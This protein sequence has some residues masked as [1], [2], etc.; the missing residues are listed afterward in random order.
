MSG[1]HH[2]LGASE[3]RTCVDGVA[4]P[5]DRQ[6]LGLTQRGLHGVGDLRLLA[7]NGFDVD[8]RAGQFDGIGE[9]GVIQMCGHGHETSHQPASL[10]ASRSQ[11]PDRATPRGRTARVVRRSIR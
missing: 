9:G 3:L 8:E 4:D 5:A 10:Q 6:V 2:P 1:E 11:R 7:G